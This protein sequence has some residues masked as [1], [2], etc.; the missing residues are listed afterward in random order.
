MNSKE[1]TSLA[2]KLLAI[3]VLIAILSQ[4]SQFSI[5]FRDFFQYDSTWFYYLPIITIGVLVGVFFLLWS[6]SN[7]VI[8]ST[9]TTKK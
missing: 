4:V 1:I 9:T 2:F 8:K 3:Y 7:K 6:L 5:F